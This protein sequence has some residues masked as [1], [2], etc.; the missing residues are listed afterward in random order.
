MR[1]TLTN[2]LRLFVFVGGAVL[3]VLLV[4]TFWPGTVLLAVPGIRVSSPYCSRW[5]AATDFNKLNKYSETERRL[6]AG[7]H[8][9]KKDGKF[10][11]WRTPKGDFWLPDGPA[12]LLPLLLTQQERHIYGRIRPGDVVIDCGAHVGTFARAALAQGASLV[13]AVEPAPDAVECFRRN[14][15]NEIAAGKVIVCPKGIWDAN[16]VLKFYLNGN[17]DAADSF[18]VHGSE[19]GSVE[20]PVTTV[21]TL[22]EQLKLPRVDLIKADVKGATE[23]ALKGAASVIARYHPRLALATEEPPENPQSIANLLSGMAPQYRLSCGPCIVVGG[24]I[25]TDVVFFE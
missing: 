10:A 19:S 12:D 9:E 24:E 7:S 6:A 21:D 1:Q 8:I 14:L 13:V 5:K 15:A 2:A 25:R 18:I 23:R 4:L 20:V 16:T 11:L 3:C 17:A 22:V